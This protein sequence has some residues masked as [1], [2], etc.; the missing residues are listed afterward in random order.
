MS[1]QRTHTPREQELLQ[2]IGENPIAVHS[3]GMHWDP[4]VGMFSERATPMV[5]L[6]QESEIP[7]DEEIEKLLKLGRDIMTRAMFSTREIE[8]LAAPGANM[9]TFF[10]K[11]DGNWTYRKMTW[12]IMWHPQPGPLEEIAE[13]ITR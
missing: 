7:T 1:E 10:K 9:Y 12:E 4:I 2:A 13:S 5:S 6:W 8:A 3:G 11:P